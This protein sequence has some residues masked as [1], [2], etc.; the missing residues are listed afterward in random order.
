MILIFEKLDGL[1][2]SIDV[3]SIVAINEDPEC[4]VIHTIV[5]DYE[6]VNDYEEVVGMVAK[7]QDESKPNIKFSK[8]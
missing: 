5:D 6:V 3:D 2:I 4:T 7:Y 8:N 1:R